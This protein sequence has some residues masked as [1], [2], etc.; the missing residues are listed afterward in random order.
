M[1]LALLIAS[2]IAAIA[3]VAVTGLALVAPAEAAGPRFA[4]DAGTQGN[5]ATSVGKIENCVQVKK[6][7]RFQMDVVVQDVTDLLA[8]DVPIDFD[9]KVVIIVDQDVKMFQQ[10]NEGSQVLD[11]SGK[12]PD[13]SGFHSI[14]AFDSADP[15]SP[16]SGSGVL[17]RITFQAVGPGTSPVRFG[18][19]D[20]DTDGKLDRGTL[21]RDINTDVIGDTNG[22]TYF[23]GEEDDAEVAV[24]GA[25]P[26][27]S[28]VAQAA[29]VSAPATGG[30][31]FPWAIAG[32]GL[33]AGIALLAGGSLVLLSRRG[34]R[35]R[36]QTE[37]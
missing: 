33:A 36:Q 12:L 8:W 17:A 2:T 15:N 31:S 4:I 28:V 26:S 5:T 1:K 30:S 14:A 10:A 24:D 27:G 29:T 11:L 3:A 34:S 20:Y 6:G 23:D 9:P 19:R 32:G 25:C 7:D 16:D 37:P 13:D 21:L 35:R 22:D 18:N